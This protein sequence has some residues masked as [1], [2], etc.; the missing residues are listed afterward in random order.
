MT[1]VKLI[2][3]EWKK[4][5]NPEISVEEKEKLKN[6][7]LPAQERKALFESVE[8]RKLQN[9]STEEKDKVQKIYDDNKIDGA[10]LIDVDIY[11]P[12]GNGIINYRVDGEHK[13]TR[14]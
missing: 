14:F 11:L 9:L 6:K 12:E 4:I 3:N 7:D 5:V 8:A 10:T 1:N 2:N 13:Q